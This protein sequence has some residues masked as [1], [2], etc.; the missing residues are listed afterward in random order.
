M[1]IKIFTEPLTQAIFDL[2]E[3]EDNDYIIGVD[4]ACLKCQDLGI[5]LDLAIGDFDS[6]T[7]EEKASIETYAKD[8]EFYKAR[9]DYTDTYLAITRALYIEHDEIIL[10]GGIGKRLDHTLANLD[11]LLLGNIS[12]QTDDTLIYVLDPGQY[13]I[14]NGFNYISFFAIEDVTKLSLS[15]FK[16][17][18]TY[19]DLKRFNPLCISNEG[20]GKLT[21]ETGCLLVIHQNEKSTD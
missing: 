10:Y 5:P 16:Y 13:T 1:K 15:G 2:Y 19:F 4:H 6:V 20:E 14:E 9:K 3:V 11:L 7:K 12:I 8:F 18:L 17:P 21:F